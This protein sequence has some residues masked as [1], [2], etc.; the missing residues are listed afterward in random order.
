MW[1]FYYG[2]WVIRPSSHALPLFDLAVGGY[3]GAWG[4]ST[5][6]AALYGG[7]RLDLD[8]LWEGD[9]LLNRRLTLLM[10]A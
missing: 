8:G 6:A 9:F 4:P 5:T 10:G 2:I 3:G 7:N 1:D